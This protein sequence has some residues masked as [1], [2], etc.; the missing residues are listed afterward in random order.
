MTGHRVHI[1]GYHDDPIWRLE[2]LHGPDEYVSYSERPTGPCRCVVDFPPGC[3]MC[4]PGPDEPDHYGCEN[5]E[6]CIDGIG[7]MCQA[8][9][10]PG[11]CYVQPFWHELG[12]ELMGGKWEGPPP[13]DVDVRWDGDYPDLRQTK[14]P[15]ND[16]G[17]FDD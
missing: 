5:Y 7:P 2:C 12:T 14:K 6:G 10:C 4:D 15:S 9:P 17:I 8:D 11:D 1:D 16:A 3:E 13:W